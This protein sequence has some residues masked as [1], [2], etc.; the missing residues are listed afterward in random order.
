MIWDCRTYEL[1]KMASDQMLSVE[2][3][4]TI[5]DATG[6]KSGKNSMPPVSWLNA[7]SFSRDGRLVIGGGADSIIRVYESESVKLVGVLIPPGCPFF[8]FIWP[9][10]YPSSDRWPFHLGSLNSIA[11]SP[12]GGTLAIGNVDGKIRLFTLK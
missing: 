12:D 9:P 3:M 6:A 5:A 1:K 2:E 11:L 7:I 4:Q 10:F 8:E